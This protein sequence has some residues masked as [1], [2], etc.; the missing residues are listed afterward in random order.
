[1]GLM[2]LTTLAP[3]QGQLEHHMTQQNVPPQRSDTRFIQLERELR[4][5]EDRWGAV[6]ANPFMGISVLDKNHYFIMTNSTYQAMV[7]YTDDELK[8]LTPLDITPCPFR[9]FDPSGLAA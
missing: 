4:A 3:R 2:G 5:N 1:M 8:K 7:G 6:F 9:K